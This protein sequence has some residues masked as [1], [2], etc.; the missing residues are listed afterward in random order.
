MPRPP[1]SKGIKGAPRA[2]PRLGDDSEQLELQ[3]GGIEV[4]PLLYPHPWAQ[5]L[6]RVGDREPEEA[7]RAPRELHTPQQRQRLGLQLRLLQEMRS[8]IGAR[9]DREVRELELERQRTPTEG[10]PREPPLEIGEHLEE[11][12][13]QLQRL[14]GIRLEGMLAADGLA[15]TLVLYWAL[16]YPASIVIVCLPSLS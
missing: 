4:Q 1:V 14:G 5:L 12:L 13:L 16:V 15:Y 2:S 9:L 11:A 6:G 3:R 8:R 10:A 7:H